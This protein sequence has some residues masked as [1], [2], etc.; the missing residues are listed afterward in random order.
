[1]RMQFFARART[2]ATVIV[3]FLL[4]IVLTGC[5]ETFPA[6]TPHQSAPHELQTDTST[7]PSPI[8]QDSGRPEGNSYT[9][10]QCGQ[11]N[12]LVQLQYLM[13]REKEAGLISETDFQNALAL[14]EKGWSAFRVLDLPETSALRQAATAA[15]N[16]DVEG[17]RRIYEYST[18]NVA[19]YCRLD[20]YEYVIT[21]GDM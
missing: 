20:G 3:S 16:L 8:P 12:T 14:I 19:Y 15:R 10:F 6:E 18:G 1:M 4:F 17:Q 21:N 2:I 5:Y 7:E 9:A 11:A 13:I